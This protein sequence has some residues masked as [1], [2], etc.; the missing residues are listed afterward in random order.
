MFWNTNL[1]CRPNF[2]LL[3]NSRTNLAPYNMNQHIITKHNSFYP[4]EIMRTPCTPWHFL[5][6]K[7]MWTLSCSLEYS[8]TYI[9]TFRKLVPNIFP[10]V[11]VRLEF[12]DEAWKLNLCKAPIWIT[13]CTSGQLLNAQILTFSSWSPMLRQILEIDIRHFPLPS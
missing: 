2:V 1:G 9:E 5:C 12:E 11:L 13:F 8:H 6:K 3:F 10:K 7:F 4:S